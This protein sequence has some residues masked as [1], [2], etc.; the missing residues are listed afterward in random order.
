MIKNSAYTGEFIKEQ[1]NAK[2]AIIY[3]SINETGIGNCCR[4][5][6]K[7]AGKFIW[8]YFKQE[9]IEIMNNVKLKIKKIC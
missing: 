7:S 1:K 4:G 9:K 6:A 3:L 2:E 8:K 5:T